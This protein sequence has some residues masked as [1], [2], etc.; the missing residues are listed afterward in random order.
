MPKKFFAVRFSDGRS[1]IATSPQRIA[2]LQ[3]NPSEYKRIVESKGFNS[4]IDATLW[5]EDPQQLPL[6]KQFFAVKVGRR[7]GLYYTQEDFDKNVLG[8]SSALGMSFYT[9]KAAKQWLWM[10][11]ETPSGL[12]TVREETTKATPGRWR[13]RNLVKALSFVRKYWMLDLIYN[14]SQNSNKW[15][16][17]NIKTNNPL[18]IYTDASC[19]K[20]NAGYSTVIIDKSAGTR[21]SLGGKLKGISDSTAAELYAIIS[22][23]KLIDS[24]SKANIEIWTDSKSIVQAVNSGNFE[25]YLKYPHSW[26][27]QFG[28]DLWKAFSELSRTHN[29]TIKWI[30]GHCGERNNTLCD[31]IAKMCRLHKLPA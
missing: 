14:L 25:D 9:E 27:V 20:N 5:L 4:D 13:I 1:E 24:E 2:E 26:A 18:I 16:Y 19:R 8:Y 6:R 7:S 31:K 29:I 28:K 3:N 23:L 15:M 10:E 22:A 17:C 12:S 11:D 21:I 30:R